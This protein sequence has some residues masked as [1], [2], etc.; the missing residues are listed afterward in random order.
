[1]EG[2]DRTASLV[3]QAD[4]AIEVLADL[5]LP[6]PVAQS[7]LRTLRAVACGPADYVAAWFERAVSGVRLGTEARERVSR[8]LAAEVVRSLP[9]NAMAV[10]QAAEHWLPNA[11]R[12]RRNRE[13][14]AVAAG[15]EVAR[16][17]SGDGPLRPVSNNWIEKFSSMVENVDEEELKRVWARILA[18]EI[19]SPGS[20]SM[21]TLRVLE[22]L[23]PESA[24]VFHSCAAECV[25]D[26][27]FFFGRRRWRDPHHREYLLLSEAGL[28]AFPDKDVGHY[29]KFDADGR[30]RIR[31]R[32]GVL[33][34]EGTPM[35]EMFLHAVPLTQAAIQLLPLV[36][37]AD[38]GQLV[39]DILSEYGHCFERA[40]LE[41]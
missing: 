25:F 41:V 33:V 8:A 9:G 38:Q 32:K 17:Y 15:V 20:Y 27:Y 19:I 40:H 21:S 2:A 14:V 16:E 37:Q 22:E 12:K 29:V 26:R 34:L 11:A 10:D 1:M 36:E 5:A 3:V 24:R 39:A 35:S 23:D 31:L 6:G 13:D 18:T 28:L 30:G 4:D 7:V